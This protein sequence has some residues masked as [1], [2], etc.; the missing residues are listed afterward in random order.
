MNKKAIILAPFFNLESSINR[1]KFIAEVLAHIVAV[2]VV[3]TNFS[4]LQKFRKKSM[5]FK[6]P[7]KIIY[8]NTL[9]YKDNKTI[10]R[11]FSHILFSLSAFVFFIKNRKDYNIVYVSVPFNLLAFLIFR[12][13]NC[14]N[15]K[16]IDI[17]D[18]WP[19]VLPI[20]KN[21]KIFGYPLMWFWK[22]LF[23]KACANAD[24]MITVSE[25]FYQEGMKYFKKRGDN[26]RCFYIGAPPLPEFQCKKEDILTIIYV[27]NIGYIYDFETL[28]DVLSD[29]IFINKFQLFIIGDGDRKEWLVE[30]LTKRKIKFKYFGVIYDSHMLGGILKSCHMGFNGYK[31]A[32][33]ATF[34][35]KASTYLSAGL[36]L[37]NSMQ[38][39]LYKLIKQNQLGYNYKSENYSN[40]KAIIKKI[41]EKQLNK[42]SRNCKNFFKTELES[43]VLKRRLLEFLRKN[44]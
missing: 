29:N 12:F 3:T 15:K 20:P 33:S 27:G 25:H 6:V 41:D 5:K 26:A 43:S 14:N 17:I 4:H 34:S 28:I 19:D 32:V 31:R 36:P 44:L 9:S 39:D 21:L 23:K 37:L 11:F 1:P 13:S 10:T 42:F 24:I 18:I 16:I 7:Y 30:E 8:L 35:Y 40:L 38:G 2:D 22:L